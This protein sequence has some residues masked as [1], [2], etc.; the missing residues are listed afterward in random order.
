MKKLCLATSV[1]LVCISSHSALGDYIQELWDDPIQQNN[2]WSYLDLDILDNPL[3]VDMTWHN[4]GGVGNSGFVSSPLDQVK[5]FHDDNAYW[6]AYLYDGLGSAQ[7]QI[8]LTITDAA[9]KIYANDISTLAQMDLKTG[10]LH[11]FVGQ[12]L[13]GTEPGPQDDKW[14]FFYN[15]SAITIND[16]NWDTESIITVGD[17]SNWDI[18]AQNNTDINASDLFYHPQ[19]WGFVIFPANDTLS[20]ELGFD[21]FGIVPEPMTIIL[22]S[23]G[24]IG[25]KRRARH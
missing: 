6:P 24:I 11:F 9:V 3:D 2:N 18:I 15:K 14:N 12:W 19:Q 22:L 1:L 17:D 10:Q 25:I 21:S 23:F 13:H 16:H 5:P 7:Q 8:D 20:G 4:N